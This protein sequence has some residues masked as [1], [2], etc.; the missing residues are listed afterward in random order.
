MNFN[1]VLP[2]SNN[3]VTV[4]DPF[5]IFSRPRTHIWTAGQ[6]QKS[7]PSQVTS[8]RVLPH[9]PLRNSDLNLRQERRRREVSPDLSQLDYQTEVRDLSPTTASDREPSLSATSKSPYQALF[10]PTMAQDPDHD[11]SI[12]SVPTTSVA[13]DQD[14]PVLSVDHDLPHWHLLM[15]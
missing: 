13:D 1:E 7:H 9:P 11:I 14:V 3:R 8:C 2:T 4:P 12:S 5:R 6:I 15:V 10:V